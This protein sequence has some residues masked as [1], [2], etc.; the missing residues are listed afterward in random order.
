MT[1][2]SIIIILTAASAGSV[3]TA[4]EKVCSTFCTNLGM[5]QSSPGRSCD[6]IYQINKASRGVSGLYWI[7]TT[8]GIHQVYCDMELQCGGH[9]GGWTRVVKF[10]TSQ[11]DSCPSGWTLITT[12]GANPKKVCRSGS[13]NECHSTIFTT[14]NTSF[15]K[16]CGQVRGYQ[17][18]YTNAF[19]IVAGDSIDVAYVDGVSI[20][21]G[22][23]RKHVW[24][25]AI[26]ISDSNLGTSSYCP[27]ATFVAADPPSFV[28]DHYYCESGDN[29]GT[30]QQTTAPAWNGLGGNDEEIYYTADPVWDGLNCSFSINCCAHPDMPWFSRHF[31]KAQNTFIEARICRNEAFSNEGTLVEM[32]ELYIQ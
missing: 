29:E 2:W 21:L 7:N 10:D 25:Y 17:K 12:P 1:V 30:Y 18:G 13:T 23:P 24:T 31:T 26:G 8:S 14:Y 20:T 15:Y 28:R 16:I 27:C 3:V 11:G 6:D 5:L 4:Q 22:N 32:M 9:K 19:G